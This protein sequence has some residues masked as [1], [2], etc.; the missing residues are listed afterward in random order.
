MPDIVLTFNIVCT[1]N[2]LTKT[3]NWICA[4]KLQTITRYTIK[5]REGGVVV[6][7]NGT[8]ILLKYWLVWAQLKSV[9][10]L[11]PVQAGHAP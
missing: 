1:E 2:L 3:P 4:G 6:N 7:Q 5:H 11:C 8:S 9:F 10:L